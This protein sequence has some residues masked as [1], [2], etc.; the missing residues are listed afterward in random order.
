M[1]ENPRHNPPVSG[2]A[3]A[4]S[5]SSGSGQHKDVGLVRARRQAEVRPLGSLSGE[6]R[7]TVI[8][9]PRPISA[10]GSATDPLSGSGSPLS[11]VGPSASARNLRVVIGR[12]F[13]VDPTGKNYMTSTTSG[14]VRLL[15]EKP[16]DAKRVTQ[17]S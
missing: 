2:R 14:L 8:Q 15:H 7:I 16:V 4:A 17:H 13:R 12:P 6:S 1:P 10:H 11:L 9:A 3:S 5:T